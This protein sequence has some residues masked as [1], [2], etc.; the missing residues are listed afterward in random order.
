MWESDFSK[1][2]LSGNKPSPVMEL[3][4]R[5][6]MSEK[7]IRVGRKSLNKQTNQAFL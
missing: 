3:P 1:C 2:W 6:Q 5:L 7:K 4:L